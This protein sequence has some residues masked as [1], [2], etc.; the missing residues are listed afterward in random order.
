[1]FGR[2]KSLLLSCPHC[3]HKQEE[4]SFARSTFC[5]KRTCGAHY[6]IEDG[7]PVPE[8]PPAAYPFPLR[9]QLADNTEELG[10]TCPKRLRKRNEQTPHVRQLEFFSAG[11]QGNDESSSPSQKTPGPPEV[12]NTT[13]GDHPALARLARLLP[14]APRKGYRHIHCLECNF[15]QSIPEQTLSTMCPRCS[16]SIPLKDYE[17]HTIRHRRIRTLGNVHIHSGGGIR[18]VSIQ[19]NNLTIEGEFAG[20][21]IVCDGDLTIACNGT[22]PGPVRCRRLSILG[23][24]EVRFLHPVEAQEAIIDGFVRGDLVCAQTLHLE[25]E[26]VLEGD[27]Q[28]RSLSISEGARHSGGLSIPRP[29]EHSPKLNEPSGGDTPGPTP[30]SAFPEPRQVTSAPRPRATPVD[31]ADD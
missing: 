6:R 18:G 4:P 22:I 20:S 7:E 1:M 13:T 31:L 28:A 21:S 3:G 8:I 5:R 25:D 17:L 26:S 14:A 30:S 9:D 10:K 11:S 16:S 24:V 29:S 15:P 23:G 19:C 2:Q 12:T 27:L